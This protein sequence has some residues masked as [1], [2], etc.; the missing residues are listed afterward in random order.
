MN[1]TDSIRE[2]KGVGEKSEKLFSKLGIYTAENLLQY[3]PREYEI[4]EPIRPI[5][6]VQ[7]GHIVVIY[8]SLLNQPK[9]KRVRNLKILSAIMK[10]GSGQIQVTWFNMPFLQKTLRLGTHYILRGR[11]IR[12]NGI[13]QLQQPKI[14]SQEEYHQLLHKLQPV[15][16]LT[17]G[18][19]NNAVTKSVKFA[20]KEME[21]NG[22]YLPLELR[23]RYQLIARKQ[24]VAG[25][26][27]P[28][29]KE[30][31]RDAR[32]RLVFEEFFLFTLALNQMKKGKSQKMSEYPFSDFGKS[33]ELEN[34]LPFA[35]TEGQKRTWCELKEDL[36]SGKVMNRLIQGDVGSGK[37]IV[38][39]LALLACVENGHQGAIMVPTEVLAT[40]H[41]QSFQEYLEPFGVKVD[42]LVGSM[43]AAAKRKIYESLEM[44]TTDIV[45]GTHA[46]IQEKVR[47]KDLALVVT[48]EQHRFGVR[49]RE[50]LWAK[51]KEPH[52]LV[53]SATPIP[54]TLAIILYGDL[55]ISIIDVMPSNRLPIKNCVVGTDYRPQA[56][57]FMQRQIQEG[58]QIYII[59]PMVEESE[60]MEAENVMDYTENLRQL[61]SPS[62][63]IS[64]LHGK[65]KASEKNLIMEEFSAGNIDILVS[66]TVI[67]VGINVPNATVMM[68]E[69]AER[70][71]LAQ[72]HQLRGRVGRGS[73]QSY[74][75]FMAG[76]ASKETMER[77]DILGHSNDGFYV[78]QEDLKLRGPGDLF[79]IRQ[80]GELNFKL[81]DI[82]QDAAIL[83]DA[84]EAAK[85]FEKKDILEMCKKY[86]GLRE[87]LLAYTDEIFL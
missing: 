41:F 46:L 80:S 74:C 4:V 55:D 21:W 19:T 20:L 29:D 12:K 9:L 11:V 3:Y 56:Y 32:K 50:G 68:I 69:N 65:M 76:N 31:Y 17:A 70:F 79:G 35:L 27:F 28:K 1:L 61:L 85:G 23:K 82:Y 52:M 53:M 83:K 38:S 58:H 10:D 44:G 78:A 18:L 84:N 5:S 81:A 71:G 48:D 62:I 64:Y 63:R 37:T 59:C 36:R 43:T 49:Q 39:V 57:H 15:Y 16:P 7:E 42:L 8:G 34:N 6:E 54:R 77:L 30:E 24:A 67:E 87:R 75:I 73:A 45:V 72:L 13:Y 14:L 2:I 22:D 66:T 51:G 40:Q 86:Q 60:N 25:I 33:E 47:Y 26:H